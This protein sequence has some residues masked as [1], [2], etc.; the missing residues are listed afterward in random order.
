MYRL[1]D[2][3]VAEC[4]QVKGCGEAY[5]IAEGEDCLGDKSY[6]RTSCWIVSASSLCVADPTKIG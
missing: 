2:T 6:Q 1:Y 4:H 3:F 5:L